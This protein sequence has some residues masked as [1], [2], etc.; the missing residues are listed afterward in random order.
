VHLP[1]GG[2]HPGSNTQTPDEHSVPD[3]HGEPSFVG[4]GPSCAYACAGGEQSWKVL[5][6]Q[7][8]K[9]VDAAHSKGVR[10]IVVVRSQPG[11]K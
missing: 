7:P 10:Q 5:P 9:T 6:S 3:V 8:Q 2:V 1:F 4:H 11:I